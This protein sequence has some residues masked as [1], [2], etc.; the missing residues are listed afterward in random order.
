MTIGSN[1]LVDLGYLHFRT[2]P[3]TMWHMTVWLSYFASPGKVD[4]PMTLP[5]CSCMV[6]ILASVFILWWLMEPQYLYDGTSE[7]GSWNMIWIHLNSRE[8]RRGQEEVGKSLGR[9]WEEVGKR[10]RRGWEELRG[11]K[12]WG[13][14]E[15][16]V[17]KI[18]DIT[19]TYCNSFSKTLIGPYCCALSTFWSSSKESWETPSLDDARWRWEGFGCASIIAI[20]RLG[21]GE[22][23]RNHPTQKNHQAQLVHVFKSRAKKRVHTELGSKLSTHVRVDLTH[24]CTNFTHQ[25]GQ[26]STKQRWG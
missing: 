10:L 6:I 14:V 11:E 19:A 3:Y 21:Q 8:M 4:W 17:E 26:R 24:D 20:R 15:K 12:R 23:C 18:W 5:S 1:D 16:R 22:L 13:W 9:G 25:N 7:Q 2:H